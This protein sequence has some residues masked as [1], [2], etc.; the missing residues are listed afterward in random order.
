MKI[1]L[2]SIFQG[3]L[4]AFPISSSMHINFF[5]PISQ[6]LINTMHLGSSL[7]FFAITLPFIWHRIK[8]INQKFNLK[9]MIKLSLLP[10]GTLI[11][12][13]IIMQ[14]KLANF[15][16][17]NYLVL[18]I[19]FALLMLFA[20]FSQSKN[21]IISLSYYQCIIISILISLSLISGVSRMGLT[22]TILRIFKLR[23]FDSL[24]LTLLIG[25]PI[26]ASV[27]M[28]ELI[29]N[30]DLQNLIYSLSAG[31]ITFFMLRITFYVLKCWWIFSL[32]RIF[33]SIILIYFFK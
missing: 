26:T 30:Y 24:I 16:P 18:N 11:T 29:K 5:Q 22:Y 33:I 1:F 10:L 14:F 20:D 25:I 13:F 7:S 6:M 27:G 17:N 3:V 9:I 32:Y 19:F 28:I 15:L 23:R 8:K 12:G 21:S 4:E 2:I 31:L